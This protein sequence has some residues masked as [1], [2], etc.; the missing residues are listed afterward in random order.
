[1]PSQ[2]E[3]NIE[4]FIS[5]IKFTDSCWLWTGP[6]TDEG[7]GQFAMQRKNGRWTTFSASRLAY[8][9]WNGC[10][11]KGHEADHFKCQNPPC[12]NPEHLE[13]VTSA[14]NSRRKKGQRPGFCQRNLHDLTKPG[15]RNGRKCRECHNEYKR[16][17][18]S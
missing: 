11:R 18:K 15:S 2:R 8:I 12:V 5:K 13:A 4:R 14:E 3:R 10:I 16:R 7:Y 1:M 17:T 9:L 6:K